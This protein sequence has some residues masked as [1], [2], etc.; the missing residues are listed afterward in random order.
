MILVA[1]T[2]GVLTGGMGQTTGVAPFTESLITALGLSRIDLSLAYMFG[3]IASSLLLTRAGKLYDRYGARV[4]ATT[5]AVVLALALLALSVCDH[6]AAAVDACLPFIGSRGSSLA[7]AILCFFVLRFSGQGVLTMV[8][9]NMMMKWFDRHRGLVTGITGMI[10]APGFSAMPLVLSKIVA[11]VGW[12]EVWQ[13]T[14][15]LIGVGF[16]LFAWFFFRDS[17]E[18]CGLKPD[19]P[20]RDRSLGANES[21]AGTRI[22]FT[23]AE[24]RRCPTFWIF[25]L[26]LSLLGFLMTG[27]TFHVASIFETAGLAAAGG[28][29][30]FLPSAIISVILRPLVGWLADRVPLKY[31]LMVMLIALMVAASALSMLGPRWTIVLLVASNGVCFSVMGTLFAMTWP[32]FFGR[33]HLGAISGFNSALCVFFS[34]LAPWMFGRC[35]AASGS[36]AA[37]ELGCAGA[38]GILLVATR[39]AKDPQGEGEK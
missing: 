12:R 36:Y 22:Q 28:F 24:A 35:L 18:V 13:V 17:A 1:G 10:I 37:V 38:A 3:T 19:G 39:W 34:A 31:L 7:V 11:A 29:A 21:R 16:A 26:G 9:Y 25:A 6:I 30:I 4:M 20:W 15:L 14:A 8:S 27:F 32:N 5:A 23:L 33:T 2:V